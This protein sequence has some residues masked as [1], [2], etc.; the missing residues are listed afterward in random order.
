MS[1][2]ATIKNQP[3]INSIYSVLSL[4]SIG[5]IAA[6]VILLLPLIV[7]ALVDH[8]AMS[9][10]AAGWVVAIDMAGYTLATVLAITWIH[11]CHWRQVTLLGMLA[12]IVGN[13]LSMLLSSFEVLALVRFI[14]GFAAGAVTAIVVAAMGKTTNPDRAYGF[15]IVGQLLLGSAGFALLPNLIASYGPAAIFA[16]L[17]VLLL[18][19]LSLIAFIPLAAADEVKPSQAAT[20]KFKLTKL[21]IYLAIAAILISYA[22]LT[23]VWSYVE[24]IAVSAGFSSA[25]IGY[26]LSIASLAGIAGGVAATLLGVRLGRVL[27]IVIAL[28]SAV[29]GVLLLKLDFSHLLY[30]VSACLF[31][32]G[33]NLMLPFFMGAI[34]AADSS[35][36]VLALANAAIGVGLMLG[37][38]VGGLFLSEADYANLTTAGISLIVISLLLITPL[39]ITAK[40]K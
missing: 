5:A 28:G 34:A 27:P 7:G 13:I 9:E 18:L 39:A 8:L 23:A 30:T 32:F 21:F 12:M 14:T 17:V 19:A 37:P 3:N 40:N 16:L 24:R 20:A 31:L 15:W 33:W 10:Q 36:R 35:S 29:V 6:A 11:R 4:A 2:I 1:L 22:G 25:L 38:G 26:S